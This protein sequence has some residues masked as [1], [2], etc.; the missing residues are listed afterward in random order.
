MVNRPSPVAK[1]QGFTLIELLTVIAII[2]VIAG[3]I[4]TI[5]GP[6]TRL[7]NLRTAQA[8]IAQIEAA[9]E[10]YKAKYGSYPPANALPAG[11]YT[12]GTNTLYSS[13]YYELCGVTNNGNYFVTLDGAAQI[14]STPPNNNDV[15]KAFGVGGFINCS[16]SGDEESVRSQNFLLGLKANRVGTVSSGGVMISNLVTSVH[17]D[18]T[19]QPV[20]IP[21]VNPFRYVYPGINNPNSYD[22]WIQLKINGK[23]NLI[24]NWSKQVIINSPMP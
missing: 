8:E 9:L 12:Y 22:L 24:C 2:G 15:Q 10:N 14:A 16:K 21:D 19:Y 17:S 1:V 11:T 7:K 20:G 23:T 6:A 18:S 3:M 4:F 5:S 13:L